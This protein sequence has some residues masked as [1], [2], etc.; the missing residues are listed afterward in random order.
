MTHFTF[1]NRYTMT[2]ETGKVIQDQEWNPQGKSQDGWQCPGCEEIFPSHHADEECVC[3][4]EDK[5][6][7]LRKPVQIVDCFNCRE[8]VLAHDFI[9]HIGNCL[10]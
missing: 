9:D 4:E 7:P 6:H 10:S 8:Y 3:G 5:P 2:D 1:T